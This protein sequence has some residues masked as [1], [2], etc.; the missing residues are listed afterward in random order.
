MVSL[1]GCATNTTPMAPVITA[2]A[3]PVQVA[4]TSATV[5]S[6]RTRDQ[7]EADSG[8]RDRPVRHARRQAVAAAHPLAAQA[9]LVMLRDGGSA[10]DAAIAAQLVLG[11]VEPQSSGLGG[12]GFLM[13]WDGQR[14]QAWDGRETAP[15][16]VGPQLFLRPDGSAMPFMEAVVGGRSVGAPGLMRMLEAVHRQHG[17]LPWARLFQPAIELA[18]TGVPIGARLRDL[19]L[20]DPALR[21]NPRARGYFYDSGGAP[22][23]VGHR[24][25][26]PDL[27]AVLR[28]I[29]AR[30]AD[31]LMT[32]PMAQRIAMAVAQ[33]PRQ[34]GT[35]T[36]DDLGRYRA[37]ERPALCHAW[38]RYLVCGM[39]PPSAGGLAVAQ[40]LTLLEPRSG[41]GSRANTTTSDDDDL[42]RWMQASRL[43]FADR[44]RYI[45]D[46]DLVPAPGG[47]WARF[48]RDGLLGQAYL[49]QRSARIG[50]CAES[51]V[52]AGEPKGF[53][54][55]MAQAPSPEQVGTTQISVVDSAG[56]AV[57][58]TSSIEAQFGSRL[59]V[60]SGRGLEGGFLLN[61]QLTD[62]SFVPMREGQ[63]VA[64]RV[65]PGKRPRSSMAPT[66]VFEREGMR[67]VMVTGSPGGPFIIPYVVKAIRASLVDGLDPQAAAALPNAGSLNGPAVLEAGRFSERRRDALE[68]RG[69]E[70][71][72]APLT[73][74]LH[75]LVRTQG[76]W[77]GGAD[78]RREG[79]V[80]VD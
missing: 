15:A 37:V 63:P 42:H 27:A 64:N 43:A 31:A 3:V 1:V 65:E 74:G 68:A 69:H 20:D 66:L 44:D 21:T 33:D 54:M 9:G 48:L 61:N 46:P 32:G 14:V 13:H 19:L 79:E 49:A 10:I 28:D 36:A 5:P 18:E 62:F 71:R 59:M 72:E 53:D 70:V 39:P 22:W 17:R 75:T 55:P 26:N 29:A 80:A 50:S 51:P 2:I 52:P 73:S 41:A 40:M 56:R 58:L 60:D 12:G 76:G 47:N 8:W 35:L 23:P 57:S 38:R 34:P 25:R 24:L 45:A 78:P 77:S 30:G 7:P 6:P 4:T 67:L 11:L 16:S